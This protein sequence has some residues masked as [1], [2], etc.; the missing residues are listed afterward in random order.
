MGSLP[1]NRLGTGNLEELQPSWAQVFIS[2][3]ICTRNT[4]MA[5][6]TNKAMLAQRCNGLKQAREQVAQHMVLLE[7]LVG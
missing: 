7:K 6:A 3:R 5:T 4:T 2:I 1:Q